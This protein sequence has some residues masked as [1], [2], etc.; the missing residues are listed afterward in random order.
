MPYPVVH[1]LFFIF[2]I[3]AVAVYATAI[4]FFRNELSSK[5]SKDLILLLFIGSL[6]TLFPDSMAIYNIIKNGTIEHCWIGPIPTHSLLF[7][8]S[9]FTFGLIAGYAVYRNFGKAIYMALFAEVAFLTHLLLDDSGE[10]GCEYLYPLYSEK[11]SIFSMM[12]VS[13]REA[14]ILH[15]LMN[16]F[17]S[18]FFIFFVLILALFSLNHFGFVFERKSEKRIDKD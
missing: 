1:V 18:V 13:F 17:V 8:F 9:A 11:I 12:D 14:G 16:S 10:G 6:C 4:S 2:C 7:S 3:G 5:N 15:Y